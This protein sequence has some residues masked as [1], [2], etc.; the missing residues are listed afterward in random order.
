M[1]QGKKPFFLKKSDERIVQLA[2]RYE[3]LK[4]KSPKKIDDVRALLHAAAALLLNGVR[5]G[6]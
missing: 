3:E 1:A 5:K 2:R 6:K 4:S